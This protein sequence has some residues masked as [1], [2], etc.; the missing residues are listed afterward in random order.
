MNDL[1]LLRQKMHRY[2]V[3]KTEKQIA[4]LNWAAWNAWASEQ[5]WYIAW[6]Y[7]QALKMSDLK[8]KRKNPNA[9]IR[10]EMEEGASFYQLRHLLL[11]ELDGLRLQRSHILKR[12]WFHTTNGQWTYS[13]KQIADAYGQNTNALNALIT[14]YDWF[15]PRV[16]MS[17][18]RFPRVS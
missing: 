13:I 15:V 5:E 6:A 2:Q 1:E 11:H 14:S 16:E 3:V 4:H 8:A 18:H 9:N 17:G 7:E 10:Y 12:L